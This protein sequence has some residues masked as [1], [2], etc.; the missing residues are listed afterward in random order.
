MTTEASQPL[1]RRLWTYQAERL[2]LAKTA[3]LTLAFSSSSVTASAAMAG[4]EAP[5]PLPYAV[6]FLLAFVVMLELR[7]L[8]EFKDAELDRLHR[9]ERPVPR[10]LVSLRLLAG[11]GVAAAA[12]A[13]SAAA[14]LAP[15]M[16]WPVLGVA[17]FM[18]AMTFHFGMPGLMHRSLL[19][20]LAS[21]MLVMPAMDLMVTAC[22]WLPRGA[23]P[24]GALWIFLA[25]SYANGCVLEIGRK[26]WAP[27]NE[28][29]HVESYS[30][31]WGIRPALAAWSA[32]LLAGMGLLAALA[33]VQG[34]FAALPVAALAFLW[35]VVSAGRFL[36]T[37]TPRTQAGLDAASGT[38]ILV[39]YLVAGYGA[40]LSR[41]IMP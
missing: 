36:R 15:G 35:A 5:G 17:A 34:G 22:E 39:S 1:A 26:T 2:P 6:A 12:L 41:W 18:A 32:C 23:P 19:L 37:P 20:T 11:I 31:A 29:P 30:S 27:G 9:P 21:H 25:L 3:L 14:Y 24:P 7:V 16:L 10:G 8:D 33:S 28:R 40:P 38:W 13:A 4:R